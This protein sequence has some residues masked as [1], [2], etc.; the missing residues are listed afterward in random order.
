ME[1]YEFK[2]DYYK[3]RLK[4]IKRMKS[5]KKCEKILIIFVRWDDKVWFLK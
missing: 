3:K 2:C 4:I 1:I 5:D